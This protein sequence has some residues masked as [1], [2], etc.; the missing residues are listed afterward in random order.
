MLCFVSDGEEA[1]KEAWESG[2]VGGYE[3]YLLADESNEAAAVYQKVGRR[4][5]GVGA[6]CLGGAGGI[7]RVKQGCVLP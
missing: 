1:E 2:E 7:V 5:G 4:R 3:A 6:V